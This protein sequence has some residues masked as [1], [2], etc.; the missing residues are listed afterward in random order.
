MSVGRTVSAATGR[1][2][3]HWVYVSAIYF[4][5]AGALFYLFLARVLPPTELGAVV[6]LQAIGT[7]VSTS[8]ALGLGSGFQ[9]FLSFYRGRKEP[10]MI[11][12]LLRS[13]VAAS[14]A[15]AVV[16]FGVTVALSGALASFL[17][18]SAAYAP[19]IEF[20][21]LY[22]G[23]ATAM[24]ILQGV[25]LGLQR[26]ALY[27][28]RSIVAYTATY[29]GAALFL[30]LWPGVRSIVAGWT[31]GAALGCLLYL[32]AMLGERDAGDPPA[33]SRADA[34]SA[35]PGG[36][37]YRTV[38]VY[39][40]PI[41]ASTLITTSATYVDRLVLASIASLASVGFYNYA[42]LF[43]GGSLVVVAPFSTVLLPR[44]SEHFGRNDTAAIRSIVRTSTTLAV[45]VY[46]PFAVAIAAL[47]PFLLR[48]LVGAAF[49]QDGV[50]LAVL[51]AL[52]A[53]AVPGTVLGSLASGIRRPNI[54][55]GSAAAA[56]TANA[57]LSVLLVPRLGI[58]G[59]AIGNSAMY[60][61]P[62]VVLYLA[63]KGT[64]LVDLDLRSI[65]RIWVAAAAMSLVVAV[66]LLE[67][68][69]RPT[70]VVAVAALGLLVLLLGLRLVR[71][72]P[73][74]AAEYILH[75]LPRRFDVLAPAVVWVA[76]HERPVV[77]GGP[78]PRT[79]LAK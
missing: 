9:H 13:S 59:A 42:L 75:V 49:V 71:A 20:L 54:L 18:R 69:Y 6:V 7:I 73:R 40:F 64:G 43:V 72:I 24:A 26:F 23:L 21:G 62:L 77:A 44:I 27:A 48:M 16:G 61:G 52:S 38:L 78:E 8:V 68:G 58:L 11:R 39:S 56:L 5:L 41:L 53:I 12:L 15:L 3:V 55:L 37:L 31:L 2:A 65:A 76:G 22:T 63:L 45:L 34:P 32:G 33:G 50:P 70:L 14:A 10:A 1:T 67:W 17:F 79:R 46:V 25:V 29:G 51:V 4:F 74:D 36:P 30:T 66:P 57:T 28:A 60:W 47:G 35:L 19:T